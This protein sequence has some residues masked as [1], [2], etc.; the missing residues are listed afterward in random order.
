MEDREIVI[1]LLKLAI[2]AKEGD[3]DTV[4]IS[5]KPEPGENI[6]YCRVMFSSEPFEDDEDEED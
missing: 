5:I 4:D 3:S 1:S 2:M 6:L